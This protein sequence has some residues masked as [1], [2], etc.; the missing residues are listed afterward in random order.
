MVSHSHIKPTHFKDQFSYLMSNSLQWTDEL[1][2]GNS[3]NITKIDNLPPTKGN[4]HTYNH[5]VLY[6]TIM[7]NY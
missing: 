5:K 7:K 4:F 2:G 6:L 3:F 1:D